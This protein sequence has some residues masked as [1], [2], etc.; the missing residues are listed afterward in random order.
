MRLYYETGENGAK[1]SCIS[2]SNGPILVGQSRESHAEIL[3]VG[4]IIGLLNNHWFLIEEGGLG[5]DRIA[6][7]LFSQCDRK[8]L[9]CKHI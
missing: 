8:L 6:V 2:H 1:I 7:T 9:N 3:R 5:L 4:S